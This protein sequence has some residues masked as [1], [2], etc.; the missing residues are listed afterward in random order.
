[1]ENNKAQQILR[2]VRAVKDNDTASFVELVGI[3]SR[4]VSSLASGY[5]LPFSE[6][7]DLC[8]EGRIALYKAAMSFDE[9]KEASFSTYASVCMTNAMTNFVNKYNSTV[10]GI[11]KDEDDIASRQDISSSDG[12]ED[13]AFSRQFRELLATRGF[14]GLSEA[15]RKT[16][17]LKVCGYKTSEISEKTGKSPKSVDNTLFRARRK[18]RSF[19]DGTK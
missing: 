5:G 10:S 12:T 6:Y 11:V 18:L 13:T 17:F 19:I 9:S 16:V 2:L 15:E 8:Q 1:M 7:D 4:T 14:A 3:F